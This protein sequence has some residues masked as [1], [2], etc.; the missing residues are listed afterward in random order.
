M[1]TLKDYMEKTKEKTEQE[2]FNSLELSENDIKVLKS[3]ILSEEVPIPALVNLI[4]REKAGK[5]IKEENKE[6]LLLRELI[7][8]NGNVT[9]KGREYINS[10]EIKE[11]LSK[12]LDG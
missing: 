4:L 3:N 9:D 1:S 7:S 6:D 2:L 11:K 12:L 5:V 8:E 10:D